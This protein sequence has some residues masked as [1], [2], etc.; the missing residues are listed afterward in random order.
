[1]IMASLTQDMAFK[2]NIIVISLLVFMELQ[3]D[4]SECPSANVDIVTQF[5]NGPSFYPISLTCCIIAHVHD[6][7][8][9]N[10]NDPSLNNG[11]RD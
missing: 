11:S 8:Q 5:I 3:L 10:L 6:Q 2:Q 4:Y 7:L 1:M 9:R